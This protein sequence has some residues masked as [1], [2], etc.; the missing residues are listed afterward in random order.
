MPITTNPLI[1]NV[2][3]TPTALRLAETSGLQLAS[4]PP[5][6]PV[7]VAT[8]KVSLHSKANKLSDS[9]Q[10]EIASL[11]VRDSKVRQHEQAHLAASAGLNVSRA[12]LTYQ[13]G[14]DGV[15]YAVGGDVSID[16]SHGRTAGENLVQGQKII[17]VAL[18]P[19]DPSPSDRSAAAAG[20]SMVGQASAELLQQS[21]QAAKTEYLATNE[22]S[23][24]QHA[25]RQAYDDSKPPRKNIDTFA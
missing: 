4:Q 22:H 21:R 17:N 7:P 16:T 8:E 13:R 19:S 3:S 24:H 1:K 5:A 11:K 14:P 2:R 18:A 15:Q 20:Q 25:L 9:Q 12:A 23:S 6:K 10:E